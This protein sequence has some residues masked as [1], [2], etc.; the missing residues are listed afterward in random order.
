MRAP[1]I[2]FA[3]LMLF[4]AWG[5]APA[6]ADIVDEAR[7]GATAQSVGG[8]APDLEQGVG[9]NLELLFES[10]EFLSVLGAP[11]P[12]IGANIA[13][14]SDATSQVYAGL[15]WK[16]RFAQRFFAAGMVGG[17]IH[18]GETDPFDP[19][20]D[21]SRATNTLFLGCRALFRLSADIGYEVTE[22]V[23]ASVHWSHISNANLCDE[24]EGLDNLG[25]RI[26]YRF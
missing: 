14:D 11:R 21:A 18:N 13:T 10:P 2:L 17:A 9:V 15:E 5:P 6:Q 26:G 12:V 19:V 8:W 22:R 24:N 16:A 3:L 25:M 20:A 7:I 4:C 23:S 1:L